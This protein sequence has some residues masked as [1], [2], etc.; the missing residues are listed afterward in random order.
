MHN[1]IYSSIWFHLTSLCLSPHF[2]S[3]FPWP[4]WP[5]VHP[6]LLPDQPSA[7][8]RMPASLFLGFTF[9]LHLATMTPSPMANCGGTEETEKY[10]KAWP[11]VLQGP[12]SKGEALCSKSTSK[13]VSDTRSAHGAHSMKEGNETLSWRIWRRDYFNPG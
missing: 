6:P 12:P 8:R 9:P 10:L 1:Q 4:S 11:P 5:Y 2:C 3:C 7:P 13:F